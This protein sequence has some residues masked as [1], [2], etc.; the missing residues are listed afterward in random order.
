MVPVRALLLESLDP[1]ATEILEDAGVSVENHVGAMDED[2]DD[3]V[4]F[5]LVLIIRYLFLTALRTSTS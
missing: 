4:S 1:R 5:L 3:S 2:E